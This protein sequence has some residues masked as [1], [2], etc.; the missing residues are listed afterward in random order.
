MT[1]QQALSQ[2]NSPPG[3]GLIYVVMPDGTTIDFPL[4]NNLSGISAARQIG[5]LSAPISGGVRAI[6]TINITA[7]AGVGLQL[8]ALTING[9]SQIGAAVTLTNLDP[10]TSAEDAATA[11]NA[12]VASPGSDYS[13]Q[14]SGGLIYL[15]DNTPGSADNGHVVIATF[16]VGVTATT[17]NIAGGG[18][19]TDYVD[20][21]TGRRI[22]VNN[23]VSAS[24][25]SLT[26]ASEVTNYFKLIGLQ[27][28]AEQVT[29]SSVVSGKITL[30][31]TA[32]IMQ[33]TLN[34]GGVLTA[35]TEIVGD[36]FEF[37]DMVILSGYSA[38]SGASI[39]NYTAGTDNIYTA[40]S[41]DLDTSGATNTG[42]FRY[43]DDATTGIGWYEMLRTTPLPATVAQMRGIGIPQLPGASTAI[44]ITSPNQA[45][46]SV[47]ITPDVTGAIY[48]ITS[49]GAV[50]MTGNYDIVL[51]GTPLE[52]DRVL[53]YGGGVAVTVTPSYLQIMGH[54][55]P[56]QVAINGLWRCEAVYGNGAWQLSFQ[57]STLDQTG[58][59]LPGY[60]IDDSA[61]GGGRG[62]DLNAKAKDLSL[63]TTKIAANAV[64]QAKMAANSVGTTELINSSVTLAK[65]DLA[66]Q[67]SIG[68]YF[69]VQRTIAA[70]DVLAFFAT[71]QTLVVAQGANIV[72]M[73]FMIMV[74]ETFN[75]AAYATNTTLRFYIQ[76]ASA[77]LETNTSV[78]PAVADIT[79]IIHIATA[80]CI[81]SKV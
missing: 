59:I 25:T 26:G 2:L 34:T 44:P 81:V 45:A 75:S 79:S 8:T 72:A 78:L 17:T 33:A 55:V 66:L 52:N 42:V 15:I 4:S 13:A 47:I 1:Q 28:A 74:R 40:N 19:G 61:F 11:I 41:A 57:P 20:N 32:Q 77:N 62:I 6:G 67:A 48:Y 5:L 39:K 65:L 18:S 21:L 35:I 23:S 54:N 51:G 56:S 29:I 49:T 73:P 63:T 50:T 3:Q 43:L 71:P 10:T 38:G 7:V 46:G 30:T 22:F 70:A 9:I 60:M 58:W 69:M 24:L 14:S 16:D 53:I 68:N 27:A 80:Q 64:T 76:G 31:R 36:G 37:G 12:Y